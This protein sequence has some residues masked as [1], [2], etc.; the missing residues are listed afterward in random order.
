V[1]SPLERG[2]SAEVPRQKATLLPHY[3][4]KRFDIA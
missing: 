1:S 3:L 4:A 2:A